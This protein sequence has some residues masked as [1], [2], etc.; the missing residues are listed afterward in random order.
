MSEAQHQEPAILIGL[1]GKKKSGKDTIADY[2]VSHHGFTKIG[3]ADPIRAQVADAWAL[4]STRMLEDQDIKDTPMPRLSFAD[5]QD[6]Q[7]VFWLRKNFMSESDPRYKSRSPREI[8]QLWGDYKRDTCG[9]RHFIDLVEE[10]ILTIRAANPAARIVVSGV[11]YAASAPSPEAE[12]ELI[13]TLGGSIWHIA[14]HGLPTGDGH[15]TEK[16]LPQHRSDRTIHNCKDV[17]WLRHEARNSLSHL[18]WWEEYR[19]A[20]SSKA[21]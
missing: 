16:P 12:A 19:A 7:F 18:I 17:I 3:F 10:N 8:Q 21:A 20:Q 4:D 11:R 15:S 13:R 5:C 6:E 9:W 1:A 14:R 2:L